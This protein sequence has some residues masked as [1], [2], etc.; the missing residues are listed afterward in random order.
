MTDKRLTRRRVVEAVTTTTT[1]SLRGALSRR[2][3]RAPRA[4]SDV[5]PYFGDDNDTPALLLLKA[6]APT[7]QRFRKGTHLHVSDVVKKCVRKMALMQRMNMTHPAETIYDGQGVTFAIGEALHDFVKGRFIAAHPDKVWAEWSCPCDATR[8]VAIF[9][10]RKVQTCPVCKCAVNKHNEVA[11]EHTDYPLVGNPDLVLWLEEYGAFLV[12]EIK[13]INAANY[14][15]LVR[16]EPDHKVQVCWYWDLLKV[17]KMPVLD[18]VSVL[19]VNKEFSFK[20][21]YTEFLIDPKDESILESYRE[22]LNDYMI[23][24]DGGPLPP[25]VFCGSSTS[26]HAKKCPVA[27][28]CFGCDR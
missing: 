23:A 6:A 11:F 3:G 19:Y 24:T 12:V 2:N 1:D 14:K 28:T 22:D 20:L 25:R 16:A 13:S 17:N 27:V 18:K 8:E 21:P 4:L 5:V 9:N 26:P 15:E 7:T 10:R